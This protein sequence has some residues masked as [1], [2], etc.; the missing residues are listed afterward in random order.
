MGLPHVSHE[1][2]VPVLDGLGLLSPARAKAWL[3]DRP[4]LRSLARKTTLA[5][6]KDHL[7]AANRCLPHRA[8]LVSLQKEPT[9]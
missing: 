1:L 3:A 6:H 7:Q 2:H 4:T 8:F 9:A 5:S